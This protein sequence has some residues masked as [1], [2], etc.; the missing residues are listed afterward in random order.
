[1]IPPAAGVALVIG[2]LAGMIMILRAWQ[3]RRSP[4]PELVRKALHVGMGLVSAGL[5]WVFDSIWPVVVLCTVATTTMLLVRYLP[6]L[7]AR[8]GGVVSDVDRKSLGDIYFPLAV[9]VTFVL[10]EGDK[11]LYTIPILVLAL[12]DATSA[13]VGLR[14]GV[15]RYRATEGRK[16]AEGSTGFFIVT[17]MTVTVPLLI[18]R[19]EPGNALLI[20]AILGLL[21][22]SLEALA[23]RGLDNLFIPIGAFVMLKIFLVKSTPELT[24]RLVLAIM[25]IGFMLL[26]RRRTTLN[27]S[28]LLGAAFIGYVFGAVGG[29]RWLVAPLTL[30]VSYKTLWPSHRRRNIARVHTVHGVMSVASGGLVWLVLAAASDRAELLYVQTLSFACHLA[31]IG[32][33]RMRFELPQMPVPVLLLSCAL[34]S[35]LLILGPYVLLAGVS[36]DWLPGLLALLPIVAATTAFYYLQPGMEDCPRDTGRWFRQAI[37]A[38]LGSA[39]GLLW[40]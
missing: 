35:W 30:F 22:M 4:H 3:R 24:L 18:A 13:L 23:W 26:W 29:W 6:P 25:L 17:L 14:Y 5:P 10:T 2:V 36:S 39:V 1:V 40:L 9:G 27:A 33:A 32:T 28:A 7:S 21:V 37:I 11:L 34:K 31:I 38:G 8:F 19:A 15:H 20:A 16:S 12:A